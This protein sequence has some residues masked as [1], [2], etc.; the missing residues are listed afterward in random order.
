[1]AL[2]KYKPTSAGRRNMTTVIFKN[3]F[4]QKD[5]SVLETTENRPEKSL[6]VA[7]KSR[8]GRNRQ[9]RITSRFQ[10]GGHKHHYRIIDF[11]RNKLNIESTVKSIEYDPNRSAFIALL[12]YT[13]GEKR[14]I[15]APDGLKVGDKI[16]SSTKADIKAGNCLPLQSI[17]VGTMIHN[18]ELQPGKGGQLVRSAGNSAQFLGK[19]GKYAIIKLPSNETR[20]VL[21]VCK[22]TIGVVSNIDHGNER[23]GKAGRNRWKGKMPHVRGVAMNPVDH[24]LGGG[25]GRTSGGRHPVSPWGMPTKGYKTRKNKRTDKFIVSRRKK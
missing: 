18:I 14:Y 21:L 9:G 4:L 24:P 10:G 23:I 5:G 16:I 12:V 7:Q 25:E 15:I 8:A 22:A 13:D 3:Q 6:L 20:K 19:E 11:K 1:M 2:K 17:P